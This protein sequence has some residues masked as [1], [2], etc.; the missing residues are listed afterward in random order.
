MKKIFY[1][2]MVVLMGAGL[3]SCNNK[4]NEPEVMD[5][6]EKAIQEDLKLS[7]DTISDPTMTYRYYG[8]S[9]IFAERIDTTTNPELIG[10]IVMIEIG[11]MEKDGVAY[12]IQRDFQKGKR[13]V[14]KHT[15][16]V[17]NRVLPQTS[18]PITLNKA[19]KLFYKEAKEK[20]YKIPA[21][22]G[23]SLRSPLYPGVEEVGYYIVNPHGVG[24][25]VDAFTGA[26]K[27]VGK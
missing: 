21:I 1:L 24:Y 16:T 5:A 9:A 12:E 15:M 25:M 13:Q 8:A 20:G 3:A 23:F 22:Q 27:P 2:A 17:E 10:T 7:F 4:G 18:F 19:L 14:I 6:F 11:D 26:I